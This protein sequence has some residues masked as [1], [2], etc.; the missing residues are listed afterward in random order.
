MFHTTWHNLRPDGRKEEKL[1]K[2]GYRGMTACGISPYQ[3]KT[4]NEFIKNCQHDIVNSKEWFEDT[5]IGYS[6]NCFCWWFEDSNEKSQLEQL[7]AGFPK[8]E[9]YVEFKETDMH[10][11]KSYYSKIKKSQD[12]M[13]YS[14]KQDF[15]HN[16]NGNFVTIDYCCLSTSDPTIATY[17]K[18]RF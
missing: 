12:C 1:Y 5:D 13:I 2:L 11:V 14:G 7:L 15:I 6:N 18:M 17:F 9:H 16:I 10:N 4:I 8:R 3:E